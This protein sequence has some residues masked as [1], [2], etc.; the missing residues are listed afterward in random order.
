MQLHSKHDDRPHDGGSGVRPALRRGRGGRAADAGSHQAA[1]ALNVNLG[2]ARSGF[3]NPAV[4]PDFPSRS[5][6]DYLSGN[7]RV[8]SLGRSYSPYW[9]PV[10]G[11]R[12]HFV[13]AL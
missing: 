11:E 1:Q 8:K 4:V 6:I 9:R 12:L 2:A 10:V 3:P 7:F 5:S 13:G